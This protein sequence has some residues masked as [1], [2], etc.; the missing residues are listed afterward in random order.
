MSSGNQTG[1]GAGTHS[2]TVCALFCRPPP[3][4]KERMKRQVL[5][6]R[7]RR[8][9]RTN[10]R[11]VSR[12]LQLSQQRRAAGV[13]PSGNASR[14]HLV[15]RQFGFRDFIDWH[16]RPLHVRLR[17]V[18]WHSVSLHS[19]S[20]AASCSLP[21][22]CYTASWL[23]TINRSSFPR[24]RHRTLALVQSILSGHPCLKHLAHDE[25]TLVAPLPHPFTVLPRLASLFFLPPGEEP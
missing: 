18:M 20:G 15:S 21:L 19:P 9:A 2:H 1:R 3:C 8:L 13:T 4:A 22:H 14:F 11:T 6:V 12:Q 16:P 23:Q 5:C 17:V 10:A 24:T 25:Q 7:F